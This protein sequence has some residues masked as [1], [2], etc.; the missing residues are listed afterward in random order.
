MSAY[1]LRRLAAGLL[2]LAGVTLIV[3]LFLNFI[4]GDPIEVM[5][6]EQAERVDRAAL[7][8]A[9]GIDL[10]AHQQVLHFLSE[11]GRGELR[12]SLPPFQ[13][14]VLP[15]ILEKFPRTAILALVSMIFALGIAIPLGVLSATKK[16]SGWDRAAMFFAL[17]GVSLPRAWFGPLLILVFAVQ[18]DLLPALGDPSASTIV[19][20]ALTMGL[21]MMA[22]LSRMTRSSVLDVNREDFV[23]TA[24]AKGLSERVVVWRHIV[25]NALLPV[26]TLVGLQFGTLLAG[27]IVT[28]KIFNWP[29]LGTLL[30]TAIQQRDYNLVRACV[31]LFTF[32]YVIVNLLTDLSYGWIDPRVRVR[33]K[34][35]R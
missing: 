21:A 30:L 2:S 27:A 1:L 12:S 31:L 32:V 19:L 26:V 34:S 16:N 18:L 17:L 33:E 6:G 20:P 10:P 15:L 28:E 35:R 14:K 25:R 7:R 11:L 3:T 13:K 4:P 9:I 29:G 23:T 5:L 8:H 24:R 22:I